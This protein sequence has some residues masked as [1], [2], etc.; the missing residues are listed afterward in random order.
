MGNLTLI[1]GNFR[2][3][4]DSLFDQISDMM[5]SS[6]LH[7]CALICQ[8]RGASTY[9]M[10]RRDWDMHVLLSKSHSESILR[11][12]ALRERVRSGEIDFVFVTD[13]ALLSDMRGDVLDF[14]CEI[15]AL[16][17]S[18]NDEVEISDYGADVIRLGNAELNGRR[19]DFEYSWEWRGVEYDDNI[20]LA[21]AFAREKKIEKI[22]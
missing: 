1:R 2:S 15:I 17:P 9:E 5:L 20:S 21:T 4:G 14:P 12:E 22:I 13:D 11:L 19:T 7:K 6:G 3:I 10:D 18:G 8:D 16:V